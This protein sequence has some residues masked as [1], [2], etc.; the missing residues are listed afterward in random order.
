[1]LQDSY[2]LR[3]VLQRVGTIVRSSQNCMKRSKNLPIIPLPV[4]LMAIT[5]PA[6]LSAAATLINFWHPGVSPALWY[7]IF[8]VLI[9]FMSLCGVRVYGEV[10][11]PLPI[12]S[13]FL[14]T[15]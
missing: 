10:K 5:G 6:E 9:L 13:S 1:M 11:I 3:W 14:L 2:N 4:Y 12:G 15:Q 7:S 8:I